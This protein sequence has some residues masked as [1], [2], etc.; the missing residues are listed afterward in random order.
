MKVNVFVPAK[1]GSKFTD[2]SITYSSI[3]GE[4]TNG[5][6]APESVIINAIDESRLSPQKARARRFLIFL[7]NRRL[8]AEKLKELSLA[9]QERLRKEFEG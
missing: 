5:P 2:Y 4:Q 9:E 6:E 1:N 8:T 3:L 7:G